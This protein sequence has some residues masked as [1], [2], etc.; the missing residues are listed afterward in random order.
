M[1]PKLSTSIIVTSLTTS[2]VAVL[3]ATV[4][5]V[6]PE[7][8]NG[9]VT[10]KQWG[11]EVVA[12]IPAIFLVVA[13]PFKRAIRFTVLD[14]LFMLFVLWYVLS[15]TMIH[16]SY[17]HF[18]KQNFFDVSLWL[19]VYLFIRSIAIKNNMVW[20]IAIVWM[21][22]SLLQSGLG[23][24]QLY[25]FEHSHH[26]LFAITGTFHNPGPFSGFVVCGLPLALGIILLH[27]KP[28]VK[29][30]T[31]TTE[32]KVTQS[33]TENTHSHLQN[34]VSTQC[35]QCNNMGKSCAES[36]KE[37][38]WIGFIKEGFNLFRNQIARYSIQALAWITL[39]VILLVLPPAQSRAAWTAG[40]L[41][42]LFVF[43]SFPGQLPFR[44]NLI[45][46]FK[47]STITIRLL[48]SISLL[49]II[50][51]SL[52]GLYIMKKGSADGRLLMW[53]VSAQIIK[54]KPICGHGSGAF[55]TL[56][57]NH[58]ANWFESGKGSEAQAMVA[59]NPESPFNE[60]L[61]LWIEKGLIALLLVAAMLYV[62]FSSGKTREPSSTE[63]HCINPILISS[64]KGT[65]ITLLTFG[66]FS[67]PLSISSFILLL[68]VLAAILSSSTLTVSRPTGNKTLLITVPGVIAIITGAIYFL[69][70]RMEHYNALKTWQEADRFYTLGAYDVAA[71]T[72]ADAFPALQLNGLFL[73]MYGKALNMDKQY[74]KSIEILS[75]AKQYFSSQI[76]QNT[77]GDN[78]KALGNYSEAEAAYKN[79]TQMI[80]SLI[81]PK[82]L[83]AKLYNESGQ[84]HKAKQIAEEILIREVKVESS[85]TREIINEMEK[86]IRQQ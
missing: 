51:T 37:N 65:L 75:L 57:M 72:Y 47:N 39:I 21:M 80:P 76:I 53:Q 3:F 79:S 64:F 49:L 13:L 9:L 20:G 15:E 59:G 7:F 8:F 24:L 11:I 74:H 28:G 18:I 43:V 67:Y 82:Y 34:S 4:F 27:R 56:Y 66:M 63:S 5:L 54:E 19:V 40:I 61:N 60:L 30:N 25:G 83:L 22:T 84:H 55:N 71:E 48:I 81:F 62:L 33:S 68:I 17:S 10:S 32:E 6:K 12:I 2:I 45:R 44:D 16:T 50:T 35:S 77:L 86:I 1:N 29:S 14:L 70:Q 42:C 41:G 52:T 46:R 23:L 38:R 78:H 31:E 69:P 73:Q 58:Q 85:A 26:G 36:A